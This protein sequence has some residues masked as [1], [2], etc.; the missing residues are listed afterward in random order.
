MIE[1]TL[2][3]KYERYKILFNKMLGVD[4]HNQEKADV[5]T[6]ATKNYILYSASV[7]V[8]RALPDLRDGLK[9]SQRRA[10]YTMKDIGITHSGKFKKAARVTGTTIALY[11]PHGDT[12]VYTTMVNLS[13]PWKQNLPLIDGQGNWGSIDGD[14]PASSRYTECRMT[15]AA[16]LLFKDLEHDT[17]DFIPNY[18]G[19]EQEPTVLPAPYPLILINGVLRGSIAV[20][21]ASSILPHNPSEIIKASIALLESRKNKEDFTAED[22]LSYVPAPDF[23]TGG[24]VYNTGNMLDIIK[25]GRGNVRVRSKY[26]I[27]TN[28]KRN[29]IIVTEIPWGKLKPT[30]IQQIVDLKRNNK[31]NKLASAISTISDQSDTEIRIVI[32]IKSG[33]D[34]ELVWSYILKNTDFDTS[35]PYF[36][37][38]IDREVNSFGELAYTPKEYGLLQ[39]LN[40][41]IDHRFEVINRKYKSVKEKAEATLHIIEGF[42]K[43][44]DII[45]ELIKIIKSSKNSEIAIKKIM[46][47]YGFS[48]KQGSAILNMRLSK[49][50]SIQKKELKEE[51][52]KFKEIIK[53][54]IFILTDYPRQCELL[55]EDLKESEKV[56]GYER[57]SEIKNE[58]GSIDLEEVIP[59]EDC[60]IYLTHKGYVK[61]VPAKFINSQNRGTKGKKGIELTEGD[62]IYKIFNTHSHSNLFFITENG[63]VFA[64]KAYN[65]PD[66]NRGSYIQNIIDMEEKSQ[67]VEIVE[68]KEISENKELVL[69]TKLGNVKK[70]K[71]TEFNGAFRK[72][73]I[74]G[75]NLI[76]SDIV[77]NG[78]IVD[79]D[80]EDSV[81]IATKQ[82]KSIRFNL[83]EIKS[84]GR[85]SK[86]VRGI[87]LKE[88]DYVIKSALIENEK[89]LVC[90]ITEQGMAKVT[91]VNNL[92]LQSRAGVGVICMSLT[93]K[94]G[95]LVSLLSWPS[96]NAKKDLVTITENGVINRIKV[97]D[98]KP[99]G[100][101]TKG[102]KLVNV[103]E[104]DSIKMTILA[105]REEIEEG[106]ENE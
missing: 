12:G 83:S 30:L 67:I 93:K 21:M 14:S 24:I 29:S 72:R 79:T 43:A 49:L 22:F 15:K 20:G 38:V 78:H 23:P 87:K 4:F 86:G 99:T 73:G 102:V 9:V 39:I 35:I 33:W 90:T 66:S 36:S 82:A 34:P 53:D 74:N 2:E 31:D 97:E 76:K 55:I 52:K 50:T 96:E 37:I 81:I 56:I 63:H 91:P 19:E 106:G 46:K 18:D 41:Y 45:D 42:L 95:D 88:N 104:N 8:G 28:K 103:L 85:V 60:I 57:R 47:E 32:D 27:E 11:H 51:E 61:R 92:K 94:S 84:I 89:S 100:R 98:I 6:V 71:L 13:Q 7:V 16:S 48:E 105:D 64:T 59:K 65:I 25:S 101:V 26:H 3:Q 58:L 77:T 1:E 75:I 10:I 54:C 68:A 80:S 44:L 40:R 70:T 69:F 5:G 62:F 17:V